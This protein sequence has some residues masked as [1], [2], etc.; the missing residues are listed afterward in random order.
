MPIDTGTW[1]LWRTSEIFAIEHTTLTDPGL[2]DLHWLLTCSTAMIPTPNEPKATS[3]E[4]ILNT[5]A[6]EVESLATPSCG[7][8]SKKLDTFCGRAVV[9][10]KWVV[11]YKIEATWKVSILSIER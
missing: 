9:K 5:V 8:E 6:D 4:T 10:V 3:V 11:M 1:R 2:A 7:G